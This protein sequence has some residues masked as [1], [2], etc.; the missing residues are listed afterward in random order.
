MQIFYE[1]DSLVSKKI[2]NQL[3]ILSKQGFRQIRT[4]F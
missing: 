2:R 1:F 3:L 4:S